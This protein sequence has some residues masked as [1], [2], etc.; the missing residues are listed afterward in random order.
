MTN[1]GVKIRYGDVA[2][3]AKENFVPSV[4]TEQ[5][6][7]FVDLAQLQQYN[8]KFPGYANPCDYGSVL[9]DG[10]NEPFPENPESAALGLWSKA[11]S[12]ADG[13][14]SAPVVL[15]LTVP[16]HG[17][18]SSQGITLTFDTDNNIFCKAL[19]IQWYRYQ[20]ESGQYVLLT[21]EDGD[22][23]SV[24][25]TPDSAFYFCRKKVENYNRL[26]I[27]FSKLNMPYNRLKLRAIDYGYGTYFYGD[28]LRNVSVMQ[29]LNPISSELCVNSVDFTLDSKSDMEYSFQSKQ[30]LSVYFDGK[31][32]ATTFVS[33]SKRLSKRMWR[34]ESEDY[35]GQLAKLTFMGGM[36]VNQNAAS[37]LAKIFAQAKI[38]L[39]MAASLSAKTITGYI[40]IC[41]CRE[42]VQLICFA[43]GAVCHTAGS[44]TVKIYELSN[45]ITWQIPLSRIRQGQSFEENERVTQVRVTAHSYK[46]NDESLVAYDASESG[47]GD[48]ILVQFSEPLHSLS[49]TGGAI[50]NDAEGNSQSSANYAVIKATN[51]TCKLS[52]KKYT[53]IAAVHVKNNPDVSA[54]DLENLVEI[55]DVGLVNPSN[56]N[57]VVTR[58]F[59]EAV[60]QTT[61]YFTVSEGKQRVRYGEALYGKTKYGQ[62]NFDESLEVGDVI[63]TETEYLGSITGR[64]VSL[65]YTLNG[66]LLL[67]E[68]ELQ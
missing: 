13:S 56:V 38:P 30:P 37:L 16:N 62:W 59:R 55:T 18:Y 60:K 46:K 32:R 49:I 42:A 21:D 8:L 52:G 65:R 39:T 40:P 64:A 23:L 9:L 10:K 26:V 66:G 54:G 68:C 4:G 53:N 6:A 34:V 31:L 33:K 24:D 44:D 25:F 29:A 58:V 12:G 27:T 7:E 57:D 22:A 47:T 14:F 61:T 36:Y 28:E 19:N 43:I 48:N 41:S 45:D 15:T 17:Q 20:A 1:E 3:E 2:P 51:V 63:T 11:I 67:K 50:L 5:A 35:I